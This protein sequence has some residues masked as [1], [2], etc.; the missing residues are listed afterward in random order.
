MGSPER[1]VSK[2]TLT[3]S[4]AVG[5]GVRYQI[6]AGSGTL[7]LRF[8]RIEDAYVYTLAVGRARRDGCAADWGLI[9]RSDRI[10]GTVLPR[11]ELVPAARRW[12]LTREG[13]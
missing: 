4:E 5:A 6:L 11:G 13:A 7:P 3:E 2:M 8:A 1:G 10:D 9:E 12:W